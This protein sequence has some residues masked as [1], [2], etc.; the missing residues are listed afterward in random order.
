VVGSQT[1]AVAGPPISHPEASAKIG[2]FGPFLS[3]LFRPISI[4][5]S[6]EATRAPSFYPDT[7]KGLKIAKNRLNIRFSG[8]LRALG[9]TSMRL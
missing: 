7:G 5:T 6:E 1:L 3:G 4:R 2:H 9:H 8:A